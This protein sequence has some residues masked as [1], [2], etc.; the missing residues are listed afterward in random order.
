MHT[1]IGS[2]GGDYALVILCQHYDPKLGF[3]KVAHSRW[4]RTPSYWK[5]N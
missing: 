3:L 4:F 5:K 1:T 2:F